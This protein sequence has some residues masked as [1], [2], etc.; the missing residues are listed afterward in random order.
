MKEVALCDD[1]GKRLSFSLALLHHVSETTAS[2]K[3]EKQ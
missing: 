2:K 1:E 3:K